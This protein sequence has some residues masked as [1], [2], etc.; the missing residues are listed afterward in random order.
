MSAPRKL[1]LL[2]VNDEPQLLR[3][4]TLQAEERHHLMHELRHARERLHNLM[5]SVTDEI[6]FRGLDHR[7]VRIN[8]SAARVEL[9]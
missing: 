7:Y 1:D 6:Y 8:R 5:E 3:M 4:T 9:S 2:V